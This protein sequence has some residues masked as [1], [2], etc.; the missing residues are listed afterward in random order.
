MSLRR[1]IDDAV[2]SRRRCPGGCRQV[3]GRLRNSDH[4]R[5]G[6]EVFSRAQQQAGAQAE[7]CRIGPASQRWLPGHGLGRRT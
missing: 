2:G 4:A 3:A 6:A 5:T 7:Q 1:R